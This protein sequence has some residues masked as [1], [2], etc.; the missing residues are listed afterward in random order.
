MGVI[1]SDYIN[2]HSKLREEY[3]QRSIEKH[4]RL[5]NI[6]RIRKE[7]EKNLEISK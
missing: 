6:Q 4:K 3:I 2:Y 5:E 1:D 7:R